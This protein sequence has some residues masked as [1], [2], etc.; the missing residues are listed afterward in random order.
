MKVSLR[1]YGG[2]TGA[3]G[4]QAHVV[5]DST[6]DDEDKRELHTLVADATAEPRAG[7]TDQVRDAQTYEIEIDDDG[8]ST[9]LEAT[10]GSVPKAF[11]SLRDWLRNH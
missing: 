7:A 8:H 10:D 11:A 3:L 6:L 1:T 9:T 2:L 4:Q 5:D